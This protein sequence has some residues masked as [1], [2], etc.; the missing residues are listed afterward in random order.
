MHHIQKKNT[1][2]SVKQ[3]LPFHSIL[4]AET[5]H[6]RTTRLL[7]HHPS[8]SKQFRDISFA[9]TN[10][11]NQQDKQIRNDRILTKV[12][13]INPYV[14]TLLRTH[15][16]N[17]LSTYTYYYYMLHYLLVQ[18][19]WCSIYVRTYMY[20]NMYTY[21]DV[22]HCRQKFYNNLP[23]FL[24]LFPSWLSTFHDRQILNSLSLCV[25]FIHSIQPLFDDIYGTSIANAFFLFSGQSAD[26][27]INNCLS[28]VKF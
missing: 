26:R 28:Y 7:A 4:E 2:K 5:R 9:K 24:L 22:V 21:I 27:Y 25:K 12:I 14:G 13:K 11:Q 20:S 1:I 8:S 6:K 23:K 18:E 10:T 19:I 16:P 17:S 3:K 15:R